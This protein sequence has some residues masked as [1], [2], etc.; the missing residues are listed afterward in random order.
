MDTEMRDMAKDH[1]RVAMNAP[2]SFL[3]TSC[4]FFIM[5]LARH[6]HGRY[7]DKGRQRQAAEDD[8]EKRQREDSAFSHDNVQV[9]WSS[10]SCQHICRI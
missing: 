1:G 10:W 5:T 6:Q 7:G 9:S 3:I 8:P 4:S 2:F